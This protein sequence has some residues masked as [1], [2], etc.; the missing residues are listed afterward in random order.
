M[1]CFALIKEMP[2]WCSFDC[3][4][5]LEHNSQTHWMCECIIFLSKGFKMSVETCL[6][7][8]PRL[9]TTQERHEICA[10]ASLFWFQCWAHRPRFRQEKFWKQDE[11]ST[12]AIKTWQQFHPVTHSKLFVCWVYNDKQQKLTFFKIKCEWLC[13]WLE[14]FFI[15]TLIV[16]H[17]A[18][19]A[20]P[21]K[22][23]CNVQ[24]F[25]SLKTNE[26]K[27]FWEPPMQMIVC[28]HWIC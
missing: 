6:L 13:H 8:D 26:P 22:L 19:L 21:I 24:F 4:P 10:T 20:H 23:A 14:W 7:L 9:G 15:L 11:N 25:A 16:F 17:K 2:F 5:G 12:C 18:T 3:L 27:K 28:C 1:G